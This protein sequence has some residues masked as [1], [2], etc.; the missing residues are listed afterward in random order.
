MKK[1]FNISFKMRENI[2]SLIKYHGFPLV[3]LEKDSID[4]ELIKVSECLNMNLLYILSKADVLG[5][6]V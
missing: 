6:R 5:K 1:K 2:A 3:F 4:Y